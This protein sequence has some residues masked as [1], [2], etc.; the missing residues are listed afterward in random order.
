MVQEL[1]LKLPTFMTWPI[2]FLSSVFATITVDYV[3]GFVSSIPSFILGNG[4][5]FTILSVVFLISTFPFY[6]MWFIAAVW[7]FFIL[8]LSTAI[9][10]LVLMFDKV[11]WVMRNFKKMI[12]IIASTKRLVSSVRSPAPPAGGPKTKDD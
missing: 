6:A 8:Q 2:R 1:Y 12:A 9:F 7:G 10:F 3:W 11:N 5:I 4:K